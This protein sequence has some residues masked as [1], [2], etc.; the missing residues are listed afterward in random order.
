[1]SAGDTFVLTVGYISIIFGLLTLSIMPFAFPGVHIPLSVLLT[2]IIALAP[3]LL[4]ALFA[5]SMPRAGGDFLYVGRVLHPVLG[6]MANFNMTLW[7]TF[8]QAIQSGWVVG[9][10]LSGMLFGLGIFTGNKALLDAAA[11][12]QQSGWR[13]IGAIIVLGAITVLLLRGFRALMKAMYALF[14]VMLAGLGVGIVA[15]FLTSN[16]DLEAALRHAG[17]SQSALLA[18][19]SQNGYN[20]GAGFALL[21]TIMAMP[22]MWAV[23]GFSQVGAY[24][25]GEI[26]SPRRNTL[27]S[28]VGSVLFVTVIFALTAAAVTHFVGSNFIGAMENLFQTGNKA[29]PFPIE[30][31]VYLYPTLTAG[32]IFVPFMVW[33]AFLLGGILSIPPSLLV[34]TRNVF[35]WSFDRVLP[36]ALSDVDEK[37][38]AP[39][40][41]I[42]IVSAVVVVC[43][44]I[45][46]FGPSNFTT[47]AF[48]GS[49]G[50]MLT[51]ILV[52]IAG[53][54]FKYRRP[55]LHNSSPYRGSILGF[56][57]FTWLGGISLVM[58]GV[59]FYWLMTNA[60]LG[61]NSALGIGAIVVIMSLGAVIYAISYFVNK[62]RGIDLLAAQ[63]E[64]PPE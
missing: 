35:A 15:M 14:F 18:A 43:A 34:V 8:F 50:Q 59:Y 39:R 27:I 61:A 1:M 42:L 17:T 31:T 33:L 60:A 23:I 24:A 58:Y 4:Y 30:P 62:G 52:A 41:A 46:I 3:A 21:A 56:S 13:F 54:L 57:I 40:N 9:T 32:N 20:S 55:D 47:F 51:F 44:V 5:A 6:F 10:G 2:G 16:A 64:L 45:F 19:A 63:K 25:A 28:I 26:R 11:S 48:S 37:Y 36:S 53:I 49:A 38:H 12:L 22:L 7:V 29:Y